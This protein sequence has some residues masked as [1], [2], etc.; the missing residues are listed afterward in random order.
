MGAVRCRP[1]TPWPDSRS[2]LALT[3]PYPRV[4]TAS[5]TPGFPLR[6]SFGALVAT[7]RLH[8][9][10]ARQD[11][12]C[13]VIASRTESMSGGFRTRYP[14]QDR[15]LLSCRLLLSSIFPSHRFW[16]V[17][18]CVG[19]GV[20]IFR[21]TL[22]S[23]HFSTPAHKIPQSTSRNT[24]ALMHFRAIASLHWLYSMKSN[25]FPSDTTWRL[26]RSVFVAHFAVVSGQVFYY[27]PFAN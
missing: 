8:H 23:P 11:R 6:Y 7:T 15:A 10:R 26:Q 25:R 5:I 2:P 12:G 16:L 9:P 22:K 1:R 20:K 19:A 4:L 14:S 24:R 3:A 17:A 13:P 18:L 27:I 21:V